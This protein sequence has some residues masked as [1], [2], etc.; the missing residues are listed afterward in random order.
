MTMLPRILAAVIA[1]WALGSAAHA[2][3]MVIGAG[4]ARL[5]YEAAEMDRVGRSSLANCDKAFAEESLSA[6]DRVATHVNR[7]IIRAQLGDWQGALDDYD[8][9]LALDPD[10]AEAYL[11]KAALLLKR[12]DWTSARP[13]FDRAIEKRTSRPELAYF[14]R[15]VAAEMAGDMRRAYEDYGRASAAAPKWEAPQKELTRFTVKRR[16]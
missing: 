13:L 15:A 8:R 3:T 1:L 14:G 2:G 7:G 12:D 16:G 6:A 10:E 11:N 4:Y 9:A 5:C